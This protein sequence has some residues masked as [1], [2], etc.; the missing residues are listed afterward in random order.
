MA[1]LTIR[2]A[3]EEEFATAVDWAAA[4]G[5]NPGLD[6]LA[7]F[8]GVDPAGFLMGFAGDKPVSSISVVRYGRGFGFLGFYIVHPDH[9]GTGLGIATWRAGMEHLGE[10]TVG[11]DGVVAQQHN[12][13]K[14]GFV[15]AGNNLRHTGTVAIDKAPAGVRRATATDVTALAA[16]D[17][18]HFPAPRDGFV[19]DWVTGPRTALIADRDGYIAGYGVIRA[20]RT[21][22]KIGP[23]FADD[24][25]VAYDLFVALC[26]SLD[27]P[28]EVSLDTPDGN[29][30][31]VRLAERFGL[32]PVF[33]TARMYRGPAPA[34]P[35]SSVFGVTTFELG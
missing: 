27:G 18:R 30:S 11:L 14:S 4:E 2:A 10:R 5:W 16:Y 21:G 7:A 12:Y 1:T 24:E 34:S 17:R 3:S 9:R 29:Q 35:T 32:A 25:T 31:A 23:L 33:E 26:A 15:L 6:D 13:R 22:F 8:H 19:R 20:C 28:A